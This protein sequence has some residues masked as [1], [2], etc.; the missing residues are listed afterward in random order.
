VRTTEL[1]FE[2]LRT[3]AG[4]EQQGGRALLR[5]AGYLADGS[6]TGLVW[7]PL[8]LRVR[9]RSERLIR[10][11][12]AG[13]QGQETGVPLPAPDAAAL[14]ALAGVAG[15]LVRS[16]RQLPR[17]IY[18]LQPRSG[19]TSCGPLQLDGLTFQPDETTLA[20]AHERLQAAFQRIF[21]HC[22][23]EVLSAEAGAGRQE[24]LL[25]DPAG[26]VA[27]LECPA[28][29]YLARQDAA[30]FHRSGSTGAEARPLREVATPGASTI[31]GLAAQLGITPA[32]TAKAVFLRATD[33]SGAD[34]ADERLV[35]AVVRGDMMLS[36]WKLARQL[37]IHGL[38]PATE[39]EIAAAGA[40]AGYGSPIGVKRS[41]V[42]LVADEAVA[43]TPNLVAGANRPGH[44]LLDTNYGRDYQADVLAD[45]A[46]AESGSTCARCPASLKLLRGSSLGQLC[47]P[48][49]LAPAL[50]YLDGNNFGQPVRLASFSLNVDELLLGA[51]RVNQDAEGLCWPRGL[52][53]FQ[54][55]V[56][57]LAA[58]D[59]PAV[60]E[61]AE[62]IHRDLRA[63]GVDVLLD[64]RDAR[65]GVKFTDADLLGIP[66][67]ITVGSRGVHEGVLEVKQRGSGAISS[68]PAVDI[69]REVA[70]LA[71]VQPA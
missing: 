1:L 53:P 69:V 39:W 50:Q 70:A 6:G 16:H 59:E 54:V 60:Q 17:T 36:E 41:S 19:A 21:V 2:T 9:Q 27:L 67:R 30:Q 7:L 25:E 12:L 28:C 26:S 33:E 10:A 55:L 15:R 24:F 52:A 61:L 11:E 18:Q 40:E 43:V 44:H 47:K 66:L 20:A 56:T 29:G 5:R 8:G 13:L 68:I 49:V 63:A 23:L 51:A 71:G 34:S 14:T 65:A 45:I 38:R 58:R 64:D 22:G 57:L 35:F 32:Q 37:G 62:S 42:I 3:S 31:E 46:Q 48:D 4:P